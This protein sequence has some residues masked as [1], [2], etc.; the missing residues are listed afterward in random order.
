MQKIL[1][2]AGI[3]IAVLAASSQAQGA[4]ETKDW[5]G[6]GTVEDKDVSAFARFRLDRD[7]DKL[8]ILLWNTAPSSKGAGSVLTNLEFNWSATLGKRTGGVLDGPQGSVMVA[9]ASELGLDLGYASIVVKKKVTDPDGP[10][11]SG[12]WAFAVGDVIPA[13][14]GTTSFDY[15]ISATSFNGALEEIRFDGSLTSGNHS[16]FGPFNGGDWG[17]GTPDF[18]GANEAYVDHA[19]L[20]SMVVQAYEGGAGLDDLTDVTF[21]YGSE[22]AGVTGFVPGKP[23]PAPPIPEPSALVIWSV[24]GLCGIGIGWYRR[25]RAA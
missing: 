16:E 25:R 17:L 12:G 14:G 7:T 20:I 1:I 8:N 19:V 22:R 4:V 11:I 18:K 23:P 2:T 6:I 24:L 21:T 3:G 13:G 9:G 15:G 5:V 10:N